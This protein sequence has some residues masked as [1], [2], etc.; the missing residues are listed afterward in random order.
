LIGIVVMLPLIG[1]LVNFLMRTMPDKKV[2]VAT[3]IY[4]SDSSSE[5]PDT[6]IEAVRKET[7]H[8]YDNAFSII[9]HGL[10]LHQHDILANQPLEEVAL[11]SNSVMEINIDAA[12]ESNV[13]GLY[14][15][16]V[17]FISRTQA[18]MDQEQGEEMFALRAAGRDI[19]EAIKDTKHMQKNMSQYIISDNSD[20]RIEYNKIRAYLGSVLRRLEKVRQEGGDPTSIL[21]LDAMKLE[22]KENDSTVNGMLETLIRENK[23][24]P[25]MATS[26][27]NDASYAYHVTNNLVQMGEV[28]FATGSQSM[29]DAERLIALDDD[30]VTEA[31]AFN[32]NQSE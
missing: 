26:L 32:N 31:L 24:T 23:I 10:S 13:K 29:K 8:L 14:S 4:L 27:M 28:L 3:P 9:A 11:A 25:L 7:L 19:V 20:I 6:A 16:I 30:D 17:G 2:S 12:Y 5:L 22:M 15:D 1:T 21:S 18:G